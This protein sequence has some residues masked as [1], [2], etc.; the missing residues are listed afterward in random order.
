MHSLAPPYVSC[1]YAVHIRS[2]HEKAV[3]QSL[4][5]RGVDCFLPTYET[6]SRWKDRRIL[7]ERPL[8]RGYAFV[9][10]S[11]AEKMSVMTVS[12]VVQVLCNRP[13]HDAVCDSLINGLRQDCSTHQ[14][15]ACAYPATGQDVTIVRGAFAGM[16]GILLHHKKPNRVVIKVAEIM[17]AFSIEVDLDDVRCTDKMLTEAFA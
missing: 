10:I 12:G 1:W 7:L 6:M 15:E 4:L 17:C 3:T 9:R 13:V 2:N 8:F 14:P 11:A 5:A 16:R